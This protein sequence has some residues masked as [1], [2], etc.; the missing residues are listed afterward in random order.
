MYS[1]FSKGMHAC[2]H[3]DIHWYADHDLGCGF[4]CTNLSLNPPV[5][6]RRRMCRCSRLD[7]SYL[8]VYYSSHL[9]L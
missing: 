8:P 5:M 3:A 1:Q 7:L 9:P 2:L 4:V 6:E